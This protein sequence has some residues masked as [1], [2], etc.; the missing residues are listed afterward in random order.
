MGAK[1]SEKVGYQRDG[2]GDEPVLGGGGIDD[3]KIVSA[4]NQCEEWS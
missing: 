3:W 4:P 2:A 1:F